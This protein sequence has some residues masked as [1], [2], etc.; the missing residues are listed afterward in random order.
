MKMQIDQTMLDK[1]FAQLR[2]IHTSH[3][4]TPK[5]EEVKK[6]IERTGTFS[7]RIGANPWVAEVKITM[8]KITYDTNQEL[9]ERMR[10]KME[11]MKNK[12]DNSVRV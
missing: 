10:K 7:F 3:W 12:F 8:D 1:L 11:E 9:P 2:I 4:K 6:E 5:L